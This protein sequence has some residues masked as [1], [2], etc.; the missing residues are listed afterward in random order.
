[1][2]LDRQTVSIA[3]TQGLDTKSDPK[4]VIPGKLVTLENGY[5]KRT[6]SILK[7]PGYVPLPTSSVPATPMAS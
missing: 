3:L 2:P 7:R 4:Q 1:M 5:F 6:G